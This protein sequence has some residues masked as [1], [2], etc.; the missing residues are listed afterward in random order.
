MERVGTSPVVQWLRRLSPKVG[1]QV[2]SLVK[3]LDPVCRN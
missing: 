1:A 3:E 2:Q